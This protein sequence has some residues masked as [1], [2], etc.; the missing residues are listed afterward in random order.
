MSRKKFTIHRKDILINRSKLRNLLDNNKIDNKGMD[1][2]EL[3]RRISEKYGLDLSYKG[4]MSLLQNRSTW[5]LIY[6]YAIADVLN[7]EIDEIFEVVDVDVDKV[8]KE[9]EEWIKKYQKKVKD[10]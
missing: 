2:L 9:K 3:H 10:D 4:F 6:A 8:V 7:V 1:Y 5:K